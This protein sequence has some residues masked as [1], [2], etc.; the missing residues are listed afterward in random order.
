MTEEC[1]SFCFECR[2][3]ECFPR[4]CVVMEQLS[5]IRQ[6]MNQ[7]LTYFFWLFLKRKEVIY[8]TGSRWRRKA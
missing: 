4:F 5:I 8:I 1:G 7:L 2:F 3:T 6:M